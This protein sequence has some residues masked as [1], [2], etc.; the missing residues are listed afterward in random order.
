MNKTI[1]RILNGIYDDLRDFFDFDMFDTLLLDKQSDDYINVDRKVLQAAKY[2]KDQGKQ[3]DNQTIECQIKLS[4]VK[5]YNLIYLLYN[6]Y[7]NYFFDTKDINVFTN[8][9]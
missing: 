3:V 1:H 5:Q 9:Q 6:F 2:Y 8:F 7:Q 4:Y